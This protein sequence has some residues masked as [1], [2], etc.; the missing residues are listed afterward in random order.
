MWNKLIF[1]L[2]GQK[3]C[4]KNTTAKFM[5]ERF[6]ENYPL[7]FGQQNP[8]IA[9]PMEY[10]FADSLK[11]ICRVLFGLTPEQCYGTDSEKNQEVARWEIFSEEIRA[12]Y[13][14][15]KMSALSARQILQVFGTDICRRFLYPNIWVDCLLRQIEE[16]KANVILITDIRFQ[17]EVEAIQGVGGKVIRI[18]RDMPDTGDLHA[19]E[20]ELVSIPDD[21]FDHV[22]PKEKNTTLDVLRQ[23]V[24]EI[25]DQYQVGGR[26]PRRINV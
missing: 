11:H 24:F 5:R 20:Q 15:N 3:Q 21:K 13:K 19:S 8:V 7:V 17:N 2:A 23:S 10:A 22:I 12:K 16:S 14:K 18:Y 25:V 6:E 9:R 4:G 1:G 26:M